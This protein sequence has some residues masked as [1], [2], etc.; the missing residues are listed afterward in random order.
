MTVIFRVLILGFKNFG[1]CCS[2]L[3]VLFSP[4]QMQAWPTNRPLTPSTHTKCVHNREVLSPHHTRSPLTS[5]DV[6]LRLPF[7]LLSSFRTYSRSPLSFIFASRVS[8]FL[9]SSICCM[10]TAADVQFCPTVAASGVWTLVCRL[11]HRLVRC[12]FLC[13]LLL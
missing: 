7:G 8:G 5:S 12:S 10:H 3:R 1:S 2:C 13:S 11:L 9:S 4:R 6:F